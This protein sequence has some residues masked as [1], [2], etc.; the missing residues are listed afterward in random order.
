MP[1]IL[2]DKAAYH[3]V[4]CRAPGPLHT[5]T[6]ENHAG[7]LV[8]D[9]SPGEIPEPKYCSLPSGLLVFHFRGPSPWSMPSAPSSNPCKWLLAPCWRESF[10]WAIHREGAALW[11]SDQNDHAGIWQWM[12]GLL[13]LLDSGTLAYNKEKGK[14]I[15]V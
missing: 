1:K 4:E 15:Y 5:W 3:L 6:V 10:D 13:R 7:V 8:F 2:Y 12:R 9:I 11:L 14:L